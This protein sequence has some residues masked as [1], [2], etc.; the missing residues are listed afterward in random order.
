M[1]YKHRNYSYRRFGSPITPLAQLK[2]ESKMT[3][4]ATMANA[5][6]T[7]IQTGLAATE[8]SQSVILSP[9]EG[10]DTDDFRTFK[11]QIT[12]SVALANV[13]EASKLEYLKLH[14]SGGALAYYLE[15]PNTSR[16]TFDNAIGS[17]ETRYLS[18]NR[19]ELFK[20]KYQERKFNQSRESA[21]DYLTDITRLANI[22]FPDATGVNRSAERT[23]L[24]EMHSSVECQIQLD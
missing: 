20:L 2:P 12:S 10:K 19:I 8:S 3:D 17:L 9:F 15:L 11:E 1:I 6:T 21:E 5:I 4:V 23:R 13:P 7:A 24:F 22:A 14:L 18:P 16:N